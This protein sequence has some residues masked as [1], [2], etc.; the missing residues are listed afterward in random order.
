MSV[1]IILYA[2]ASLGITNYKWRMNG[3][4]VEEV[5]FG[6]REDCHTLNIGLNENCTDIEIFQYNTLV[7][8]G[9]KFNNQCETLTCVINNY[10]VL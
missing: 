6:V 9:K 10:D 4:E 8:D 3:S 2:T 5:Y 1:P 7:N